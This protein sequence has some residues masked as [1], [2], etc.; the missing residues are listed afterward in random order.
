MYIYV[1]IFVNLWKMS[2]ESR[3]PEISWGQ[4][5][6]FQAKDCFFSIIPMYLR[7][8]L[9]Q[10]KEYHFLGKS[11]LCHCTSQQH[12]YT[13]PV[14][15]VAGLGLKG[16]SKEEKWTAKAMIEYQF[17]LSSLDRCT[18]PLSRS[19]L[20]RCFSALSVCLWGVSLCV[21]SS[22]IA[23]QRPGSSD[24]NSSPLTLGS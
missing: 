3:L 18:H 8:K 5:T 24:L 23:K 21:K 20:Y 4:C 1:Y 11:Q 16:F 12:T 2:I 9:K 22:Y 15:P 6:E 19:P 13:T 14:R 7:F 17:H 10:I